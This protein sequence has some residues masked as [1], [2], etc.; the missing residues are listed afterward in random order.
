[1]VINKL[2]VSSCMAIALAGCA[3][4]APTTTSSNSSQEIDVFTVDVE[5]EMVSEAEAAVRGK[6]KDPDS[7]QFRNVHGASPVEGGP[8]MAVCGEFNSKNGYG[9]Y[10][11]YA[12]FAYS[13]GKAYIWRDTERF[14]AENT[15]IEMSCGT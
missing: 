3:T 11:G 1:M 12:P 8:L 5:Q 13:Q 2:L 4:Q 14:S 6:L 7:T 9:G 15:M 10:V